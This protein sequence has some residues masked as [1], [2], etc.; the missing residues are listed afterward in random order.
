MKDGIYV[1]YF[2]DRIVVYFAE[3]ISMADISQYC[4]GTVDAN[5]F[6]RVKEDGNLAD[7]IF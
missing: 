3:N 1:G 2:Y 5:E 7:L 6:L 4:E